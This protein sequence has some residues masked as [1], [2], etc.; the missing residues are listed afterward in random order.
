MAT[1]NSSPP[2]S[3]THNFPLVVIGQ[4]SYHALSAPLAGSLS[5]RLQGPLRPVIYPIR[6]VQHR[7]SHATADRLPVKLQFA[8]V[9]CYVPDSR[10]QAVLN[11]NFHSKVRKDEKRR[12]RSDERIEQG[13]RLGHS[14]SY[15]LI[16]RTKGK[17]QKHNEQRSAR[18]EAA[19]A[20]RH[21]PIQSAL[22]RS[23]LRSLATSLTSSW[24][25]WEELDDESAVTNVLCGGQQ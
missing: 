12:K 20:K 18:I 9:P 14:L 15:A 17:L 3:P 11:P 13:A 19:I 8:F 1:H 4:S 23:R 6:T 21:C 25:K 5:A 24:R 2:T 22:S 16:P 10:R 7:K